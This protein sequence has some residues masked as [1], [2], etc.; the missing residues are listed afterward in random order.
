MPA[1]QSPAASRRTLG[2]FAKEPRP[3]RVKSRLAAQTNPAWAAEVAAAFLHDFV[4]R[5]VVLEA[6][7]V[8]VFDPPQAREYFEKVA[9][10]RFTLVP[11]SA[12]DLGQRL[13]AFVRQE[14][15]AGAEQV[16]LLGAD[17]PTLP[18]G[19]VEQAF[20]EL[21]RADVVLGPA[22]DGG[23]YLLGCARRL[24]PVFDGI[25]WGGP[26][27]LHDTVARLGGWK[28]ALLPP[29]YDVDTLNDWWALRGHL[30]ALRQAGF[31]PGVPRTEA[32]SNPPPITDL[33]PHAPVA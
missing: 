24:P 27:V 31:D 14:L 17:S 6:R 9:R 11:Q 1:D 13:A 15:D 22:T 20:R 32:L 3:G 8:L 4:E 23:Y 33:E 16:V 19:H 25:A 30:A 28:L 2:I 18:P 7:R 10:N 12:G 5:L 29:W 26:R 21:A